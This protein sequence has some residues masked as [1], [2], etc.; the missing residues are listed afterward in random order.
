MATS[1]C[2]K[3]MS[4]AALKITSAYP[5]NQMLF[6]GQNTD[7]FNDGRAPDN[8]NVSVFNQLYE[9]KGEA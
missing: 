3:I 5:P 8:K 9:R 1:K 4:E 2:G 7:N 6:N